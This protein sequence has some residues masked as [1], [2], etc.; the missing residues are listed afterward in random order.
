MTRPNTLQILADLKAA[1]LDVSSLERQINVD[2]IAKRQADS[3]IAGGILRQQDYTRY[4]NDVAQREQQ[5]QQQVQK[6]ATLHD[7]QNS[8]VDLPQATLDTIKK[9]EEALIATGEFDE[10]S[11]K[12]LSY[13][14]SVPLQRMIQDR[15]RQPNPQNLPNQNQNNNNNNDLDNGRQFQPTNF[16]PTQFVDVNTLRGAMANLAYG[17]IATTMEINARLEELKELGIK[18]TRDSIKKLQENLK[19][20]FEGGGNLDQAFEETFEV[21]KALQAQQ[22]TIFQNRV[23]SEVDKQV[24]EKLKEAGLPPVK[25]NGFKPRHV[26]LNRKSQTPANLQPSEGDN[27]TTDGINPPPVNNELPKNKDGEVEYYKLRGDRSSR[28]ASASALLDTVNE[29]YANDPTFVE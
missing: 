8:G 2:P 1:G 7:A 23:Q 11:I 3:L 22:E 29:H 26:L 4:M 17:D 5:L 12:Q 20:N 10:E 28:L 6:L 25:K 9:M 24:A 16:D 18:V 21:S 15:N 27:K 19:K 14:G 13:H